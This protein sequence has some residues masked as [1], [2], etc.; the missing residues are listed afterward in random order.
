MF[1]EKKIES[2]CTRDMTFLLGQQLQL[3][4][5]VKNLQIEEAETSEAFYIN[6]EVGS[7]TGGGGTVYPV[8][9]RCRNQTGE[10]EDFGCEC[11]AFQEEPGMCRHCVA[12]ALAY[13]DQKKS[14]ERMKLYRGLLA[15]PRKEH[16]D[17]EML[18]TM[19]AYA[20]RRRMQEQKPEGTIELIPK[21]YET[22]RN[23]YYG[24]KSYELTFQIQENGG[25]SYVLR[26]LSDFIEAIKKE[27]TYTYGKRLSFVH[28]KSIFTE[29][30]WQYVQLIWDGI[31]ISNTGNE[32][33]AKELPLN[34]MLMERFFELNLNQEI[35][36]ES[37]GC[38]YETLQVLDENPPVKI[39][40]R[41]ESG[42][43]FR[44]W[45]PP[46]AI[47]KGEHALFVR[48]REKVYRCTAEYRHAMERLLECADEDKAVK[49]K[50]AQEDMPLFCSAVLPELEQE[51][52]IEARGLSLE[53]YRPKEAMFAFYLDEED[54]TVTLRTECRYGEYLY[55]LLRPE[56]DGRRD[57]VR[58]KQVLEVAR[59]YF[60]YED[61]ERG[62]FCFA[63]S[64]Q[65]RMYQLLGTGIRQLEQ[66]GK[67]YA[68]DRIQS[69]RLLRAPKVQVGVSMS[70]GLLKLTVSS[71]AFT[72]EELE[73]VL[74]SYRRKKKYHRLRSGDFLD[75]TDHAV[76]T[77]AEL[78]DG[79][80]LSGKQ[81]TKEQIELPGY[82]ALFV[83]QTISGHPGQVTVKKNAAYREVLRDMKRVADSDFC[84]PDGLKGTMRGYQK[85][86]YRWL[87]TLAKLGFGG[88]LADEMGLGK[89]LQ[90]IAY[91]RARREEG[92]SCSPDLIVCPAS[93]VYNWK[94]EIE[95]FAP[96]L[97]VCLLIGSAAAR[98]E[99]LRERIRQEMQLHA[100]EMANIEQ[101]ADPETIKGEK[102]DVPPAAERAAAADIWITSYDLLKRDVWLYE[103]L[104]FD[105]EIIDEA[106]NI[107][108][109]GTQ[110]AQAVK[111]ISACVRFAL[112]GTPMENRLSELWSIFDYLMPGLLG[113]YEHFRKRYELPIIQEEDAEAIKRLQRMTAPFILRRKKQEV[114]RE[115]PE[116]LEQTV[117]AQMEGEQRRLYEAERQRLQEEIAEKSGE[118]LAKSRLQILA[119][120]TKLR[121]LCCDPLLL[122]EDYTSGA[123]K[124]DTCMDLIQ[125]AAESKHKVL[126]FSQF[127]SMFPILEE[128]LKMEGI[129]YYELTG[130]TPKEERQRLTDA[131]N[132]DAVPVFL[133]SLKAGG[134]G[135]NLTAANIVIHFDPWWNLAAQN[136]ATDRAHR[137]G[138][139]NKVTVFRLIAQG[140]IEE[141]IVELQEKKQE[142]AEKII[143]GEAVSDATL[144]KEELLEIL[145]DR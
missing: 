144:T 63:A 52:A 120:L 108:N 133:I 116:K 75:L 34:R 72:R 126:L 74:E 35:A 123:C 83:N 143:A 56:Q 27:E 142:L 93:L 68:T 12:V 11:T 7:K 25:R 41:K 39:E 78:L 45:I 99:M 119:G 38:T 112:T 18:L 15:E 145:A 84:I 2:L 67:V 134:T 110:A 44:I 50:I 40:L 89:T 92:I 47:W 137:I 79:L 55:N 122:F 37:F 43:A 73:E 81:L 4:H 21:L 90:S 136:Q 118:E 82:R 61:L 46:L 5:T 125:T 10:I 132:Q 30:A 113:S 102:T 104:Q 139:Q 16:S 107:K 127:T 23:Y 86:G 32:K 109:H 3:L 114:L 69:H 48:M 76:T 24:R 138:Q 36:Y 60:P 124:V 26:S 59:S 14:A 29:K 140:T 20:M 42:A 58:E 33:L 80:E 131:F 54:G 91:L 19:E 51:K 57:L 135:L 71:D 31:A 141:K 105:T 22:G 13:L 101:E 103:K 96:S 62:L 77:V 115:L 95:R 128:R 94:K 17:K 88:I 65:D 111:R 8:W 1:D 9:I 6:A 66:E 28:S 121:Q 106:Q 117:Y 130:N 53:E 64:E 98:E 85:T 49:L 100:D 87:R 70:N 129:A 97:T